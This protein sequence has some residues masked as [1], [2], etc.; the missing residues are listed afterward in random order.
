MR[1]CSPKRNLRDLQAIEWTPV[2]WQ[3]CFRLCYHLH[4]N[5]RAGNLGEWWVSE[6]FV[7]SVIVSAHQDVSGVLPEE[8]STGKV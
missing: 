7:F 3:G 6:P 5:K 2:E 1:N 4:Y 8:D